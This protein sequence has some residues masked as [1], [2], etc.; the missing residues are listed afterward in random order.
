MPLITLAQ[1]GDALPDWV[2]IACFGA[3]LIALFLSLFFRREGFPAKLLTCFL[4]YASTAVAL[5]VLGPVGYCGGLAV[6]PI[7]GLLL[8]VLP[9]PSIFIDDVRTTP[10]GFPVIMPEEKKPKD[11][12]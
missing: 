7:F 1:L 4:F 8:F 9:F 5:V 12:E 2:A 10:S 6:G 3:P 11:P